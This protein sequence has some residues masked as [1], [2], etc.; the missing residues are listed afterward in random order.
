MVHE[1]YLHKAGQYQA[2]ECVGADEEGICIKESLLLWL[3]D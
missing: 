1:M 2:G 3:W